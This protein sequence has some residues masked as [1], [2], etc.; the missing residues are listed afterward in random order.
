MNPEDLLTPAHIRTA[1]GD[2]TVKTAWTQERWVENIR[3]V[4]GSE[5]DDPFV[6][7]EAVH[8]NEE[9]VQCLLTFIVTA[10]DTGAALAPDGIDL[11]DEDDAWAVLL[12]LIE[13]IA[14]AACADTDEHLNEIRAADGEERNACFAS[15][16]TSEQGFTG[17]RRAKEQHA[18]RDL[19]TDGFEFLWFLEKVDDFLEF[20]LDL[21]STSHVCKGDAVLAVDGDAGLALA[22]LV[23]LTAATLGRA[24]K[25]EEQTYQQEHRQE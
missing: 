20:F 22:K 16:C 11:V 25:E 23:H 17:P 12:G 9:L 2:L 21:V 15:Y 24:H 1:N 6:G 18:L 4:R 14:D 3:A 10:A 19:G 13:E 7:V 8:L 5:D